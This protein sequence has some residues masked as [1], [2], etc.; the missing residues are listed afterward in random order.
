MTHIWEIIFSVREALKLISELPK[1]VVHLTTLILEGFLRVSL[2]TG[3]RGWPYVTCK[4]PNDVAYISVFHLL[5]QYTL[6]IWQWHDNRK[7]AKFGNFEKPGARTLFVNK[8]TFHFKTFKTKAQRP[9]FRAKRRKEV[10]F[11]SLCFRA[12]PISISLC[13]DCLPCGKD[14]LEVSNIRPGQGYLWVQPW[15]TALKSSRLHLSLPE[16]KLTGIVL[17]FFV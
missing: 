8:A 17:I 6:A 15:V 10:I 9:S 11:Q 13:L 12:F 7:K 4:L 2:L 14:I 1:Y 3:F 5:K 16:R